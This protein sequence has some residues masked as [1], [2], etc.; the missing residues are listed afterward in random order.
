MSVDKLDELFSSQS[1][2]N[3]AIFGKRSLMGQDG[4]ILSM[5]RLVSLARG[6]AIAPG[7]D[8]A[9]WL[10]NYLKALQDE[11]R[12]LG[13]EVPWKWWSKQQ[14]DMDAVRVE[15]VDML[16]FW[17]SLALVSGL[18]P[19]ETLRLYRLK[20]EVNLRRQDT[21]YDASAKT[22]RDDLEVK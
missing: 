17:I 10:S 21:G 11:A 1:S 3:D 13:E 14:L 15:I 2:L 19:D 22:G 5:D 7:S 9:V 18:D 6:Q 20:N 12:E 8:T 16:H 4:Q